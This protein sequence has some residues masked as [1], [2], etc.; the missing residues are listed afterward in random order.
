MNGIATRC[1]RGD[2]IDEINSIHIINDRAL[3]I[4][5][6]LQDG[7]RPK[8]PLYSTS[9]QLAVLNDLIARGF[10]EELDVEYKNTRW[11]VLTEKGTLLLD[12]MMKVRAIYLSDPADTEKML[13]AYGRLTETA[14]ESTNDASDVSEYLSDGEW[15]QSGA[16]E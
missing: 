4:L 16:I 5:S 9:R 12:M 3:R 15:P 14:E 10:V 6:M 11:C 1:S 13:A 8:R 2:T 7:G